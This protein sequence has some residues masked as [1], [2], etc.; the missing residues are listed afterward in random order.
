M[1]VHFLSQIIHLDECLTIQ[2]KAKEIY[3]VLTMGRKRDLDSQEKAK[4]VKCLAEGCSSLEI[5]KIIHRD[6]RTV[7]KFVNDSQHVR[8]RVDKPSRRVL[9]GRDLAAVKREMSR[10]PISTSA[11]IFQAAGLP[12]VSRST[13][14][15]A[16]RSVGKVVKVKTMP[17]LN[18]RHKQ[19]RIE[20]CKK[21]LK[22]DFSKVIWSDEMRATLDGPDGWA[23]GWLMEGGT[24]PVRFKRQQ[25]GGGIMIWAALQKH[26]LIE[27][28]KVDDGVKMNSQNYCEFLNRHFLPCIKRQPAATRKKA[29][30]HAR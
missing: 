28:I 17:P 11:Q 22:Q 29:D 5:S 20:W 7:K 24:A 26:R 25:G 21:Y 27:P 6:H 30:V 1:P 12:H 16:L 2:S 10:K 18:K 8:T 14:C 23:R 15:R 19:R 4:I 13:R 3:S 9:S